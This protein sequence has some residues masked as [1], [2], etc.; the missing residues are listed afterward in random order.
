MLPGR[1][2]AGSM[3]SIACMATLIQILLEGAQMLE[4]IRHRRGNVDSS[5]VRRVHRVYASFVAEG[6]WSSLD[7]LG[8][9]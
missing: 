2:V 7:E 9:R 3:A 4:S 6:L 1:G 8:T 5:E